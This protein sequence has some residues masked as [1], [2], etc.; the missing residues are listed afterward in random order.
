MER[1]DQSPAPSLFPL[2][3]HNP[4]NHQLRDFDLRLAADTTLASV[5]ISKEHLIQRHEWIKGEHLTLERWEHSNQ[6]ELCEPIRIR[7]H[8]QLRDLID[9]HSDTHT[10][11]AANQLIDS[12][13]SGF[14]R[15]AGTQLAD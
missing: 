1:G 4:L 6:M 3:T 13:F 7:L 9:N 2:V 10:A 11:A 15:R 8:T 12:V 14:S 5:I